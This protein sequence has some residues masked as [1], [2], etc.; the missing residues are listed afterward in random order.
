MFDYRSRQTQLI[1]R[2]EKSGKIP[3]L[4]TSL[5]DI[6]Y[7]TGFSGT[8]AVLLFGDKGVL[9]GTDGR[10]EIQS[11][12]E[13]VS[14]ITFIYG[15]KR[16]FFKKYL[17]RGENVYVGREQLSFSEFNLYQKWSFAVHPVNSPLVRMR[18]IKDK[19]EIEIIEQAA[20]LSSTAFLAV[21]SSF[22]RTMT[23]NEVA[24]AIEFEMRRRGAEGSSFP[25][26]VA[27]GEKSAL[28]HAKP[29]GEAPGDAQISLFDFGCRHRGY[30]SDETVTLFKN[31]KKIDRELEKVMGLVRK[32]RGEALKIVKPG[33]KCRDVDLAARKIIDE[34]GYGRY[35]VHST[36]HG[37]G[38]EIHEP[39]QISRYSRDVL[40]RGMVITIEP[41][42]YIPGKGGV[43]L[44][45]LFVI[46]ENG[47]EKL[48]YLPKDNT[49]PL[50]Q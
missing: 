45:D 37:V 12:H 11:R 18:T 9:F 3:F 48:T 47:F 41:G 20:I 35:F 46:T 21:L 38:M 34:K 32:A 24:A 49:Y 10:Y 7:L 1:R 44:E 42:I 28:P 22:R 8:D 15:R 36:G 50:L 39:P 33:V 27:F 4:I 25:P 26:I 30:C 13:V 23:E 31:G 40:K 6:R 2:L 19:R 14:D 29:G 43:R 17:K 16:D 5:V